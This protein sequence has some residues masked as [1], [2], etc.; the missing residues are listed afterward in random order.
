MEAFDSAV[1]LGVCHELTESLV[2]LVRGAEGVA[3]AVAW[4]PASGPPA[5]FAARPE[6]VGRIHPVT[7]VLDEATASWA[8][9][10]SAPARYEMFDRW[11]SEVE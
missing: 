7:Q 5:G 3:V 1:G 10:F 6:P 2:R 9:D 8:F 11:Q 4:S